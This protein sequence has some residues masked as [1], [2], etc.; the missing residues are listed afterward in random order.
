MAG[1]IEKIP[2]LEL[3]I[4]FSIQPIP[5]IGKYQTVVLVIRTF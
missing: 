5:A 3:E 2:Y 1:P 4:G